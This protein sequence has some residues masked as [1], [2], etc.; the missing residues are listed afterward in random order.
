MTAY[1]ARI[2]TVNRRYASEPSVPIDF[3]TPEGCMLNNYPDLTIYYLV[4]SIVHNMQVRAVGATTILVG[5][6]PPREPN[7]IIR[8]YYLSF[9]SK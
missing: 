2:F 4:P 8:G 9:E 7:G 1:R 6:E 3:E 5:W